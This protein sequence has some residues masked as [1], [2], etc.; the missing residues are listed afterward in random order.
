MQAHEA[1][2][3][4]IIEG[5]TEFIPISSTFHLVWASHALGIGQTPFQKLFEVAIQSGAILAVLIPFIKAVREDTTIAKKVIV[6]FIP[7]GIIGFL[8][9]PM[10]KNVFLENVVLQTAVF[11]AVGIVFIFFE[12]FQKNQPMRT[13]VSMTY[14]QAAVIGIFQ[15]LAIV[16]GV[17]RAGAVMI[18]LMALSYSRKEAAQFSFFLAI[19]T[20][21]SAGAF[22]MVKSYSAI[23]TGS[24][25][26]MLTLGFFAAFIT[27]I[28][29]VRWFINYLS[30][31]TIAAFG[32]YRIIAAIGIFSLLM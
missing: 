31:H 3:L 11:G 5:I 13:I 2:L 7:T 15:A 4:G 30:R 14:A 19:P 18:T 23:E 12:R 27:S 29:V 1:I 16:P 9:Y 25:V 22:D 8:F 21:L 17:S 32:W 28:I 6:A 20:I 26:L 10:V 24:D